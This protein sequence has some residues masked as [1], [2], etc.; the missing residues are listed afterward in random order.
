MPSRVFIPMSCSS[1]ARYSKYLWLF[2]GV[3]AVF[4]SSDAYGEDVIVFDHESGAWGAVWSESKSTRT[5]DEPGLL[6][7]AQKKCKQKGATSYCGTVCMSVLTGYVAFVGAKTQ[8]GYALG[9]ALAGSPESAMR[10]AMR[11][12]TEYWGTPRIQCEV[13]QTYHTIGED[14][15]TAG[16]AR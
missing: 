9:C 5:N 13:L 8:R 11:Q 7:L 16:S 15:T 10:E 12:C 4:A 1:V 14:P 6:D 2:V 3:L